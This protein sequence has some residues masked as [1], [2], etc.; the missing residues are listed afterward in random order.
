MG[1]GG[2]GKTILLEHLLHLAGATQR[3][4]SIVEG[5]TVG[6]YLEEEKAHGHTISLKLMHLDWN[7]SR[8]HLVDHPGYA[9]FIGELVATMPILDSV[10]IVVDAMTGPQAGTD[11]AFREAEKDGTP[12]AFFI[13][14]LDRENTDFNAAVETIRSTYGNHCVP[15]EIP[16]GSGEDF[17]E[18]VNLVT[19]EHAELVDHIEDL[20]TQLADVVAETD[21]DLLEIYLETGELSAEQ[22]NEA[23]HNGIRTGKIVPILAGSAEKSVGLTEL[24]DLIVNTFPS[25][26]ERAVT[27]LDSSGAEQQAAVG[28]D[29]P[30]LGQVFRSVADPFVGQLTFFRVL[31]GT[32]KSDSSFYNVST[33]EK[34]RTGKL[35]L[36]CGK[37]QEQV[38][39]VGPGDL[40]AMTKLKN[41]HFG[42]TI[43]APG[44]TM[45]LP[46]IDMPEAIV[47]LAIEAKTRAD[48]DK[49]GE[50]LNRLAEEDPTFSHYRDDNTN[51]HLIQGMGDIH[52][53]ILVERMKSRYNVAA[54]TRVPKVAYKETIR[55]KAEAQGK[56]KKQS[57]G[58]GQYGDVHIRIKPIERGKGYEFVN[59]I[60][61]GVVPKQ[62]IPHVDKGSQE[63][64]AKGVIAGYPV[65]D[66]GVELYFGSFHDVDSSE[67]AFKIAAAMAIQKAVKDAQ[68][69]LLEPI[70]EI[71][72]TVPD[73]Y[74]GDI[75]GDLSGR[76]GRISGMEPAG[77]GRQCI[78]ASVPESEVLQYSTDLRSMSQ[79]RGTYTLKFD[80]YEE[81]PE[82]AMKE[83]VA[84]HAAETAH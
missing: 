7:G 10:V 82:H 42:N 12:C 43:A 33:S 57:G 74:M 56:H 37:D 14:K 66:V 50:A 15:L 4:G 20:R 58:H 59:S 19:G 63:T 17:C 61:G 62:Y 53:G 21:D 46:K 54:E 51:E 36:L 41:T 35:F 67:M 24:L 64:L 9:D 84:A 83:I 48:E 44:A 39:S 8:I 78:K 75:N 30:F 11:N 72:V 40:A 13:N 5:T 68:P 18:V 77:P 26:L 38:D 16:A 2:V 73:E 52:L 45:T 28:P 79:G 69:C 1:H 81:V 22:F 55:A 23:L 60:V 70:V 65:V 27:V 6:D 32:L 34:E 49:I 76:R 71:A 3:V 80:H 31:S 25:P 47:R 29:E